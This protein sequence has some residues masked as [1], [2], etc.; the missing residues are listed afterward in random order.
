M[1]N[2]GL[3]GGMQ[4]VNEEWIPTIKRHRDAD[5][6]RGQSCMQRARSAIER[7]KSIRPQPGDVAVVEIPLPPKTPS[8]V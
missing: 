3:N 5:K 6:K 4:R 2:N 7:H 1:N 8:N